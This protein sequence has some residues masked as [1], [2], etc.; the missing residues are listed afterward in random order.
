[1]IGIGLFG[2]GR[3]G[4]MHAANIARH[5]G[6]ELSQVYDVVEAAA[7]ETALQFGASAV[8]APEIILE[9]SEADA[10]M[11]A[12]STNTHADLI[13]AAARAGKAIF[14]EKPI[15]LSLDRVNRCRDAIQG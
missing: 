1:M 5:P 3:I 7:Q 4:R 13:E 8:S 10:V 11:I 12:T 6:V 14:C 9:G 15:D 2:C